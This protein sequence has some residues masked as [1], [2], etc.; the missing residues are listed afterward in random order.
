MRRVREDWV[1]RHARFLQF[2]IFSTYVFAL[3]F[4]W[5]FA[6]YSSFVG[7]LSASIWVP[8]PS[9]LASFV[10]HKSSIAFPWIRYICWHQ[11]LCFLD[12]FSVHALNLQ[13]SKNRCFSNEFKC[14]YTSGQ[15]D[16]WYFSWYLSIPVLAFFLALWHRAWVHLGILSGI[17]FNFW[18]VRIW[19][20]FGV[21][22]F[23]FVYWFCIKNG[24]QNATKSVTGCRRARAF[25]PVAI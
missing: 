12:T 7:S 24:S 21:R 11:F 2:P 8:F 14:F 17:V 20:V 1:A 5:T 19:D 15:H 10:E 4:P 23:Y 6:Y 9:I 13:T 22:Y 16:F 18:G 25:V 3:F